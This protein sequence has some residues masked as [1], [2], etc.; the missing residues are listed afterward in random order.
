MIDRATRELEA[1]LG[2]ANQ[3]EEREAEEQRRKEDET[4]AK[5]ESDR[6][7]LLAEISESRLA[8]TFFSQQC[9]RHP[10]RNQSDIC[11]AVPTGCTRRRACSR[12]LLR[13]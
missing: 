7:K 5:K 4:A 9:R 10:S 11:G 1:R 2:A 13:L 8:T 12:G 3:K 6:Q